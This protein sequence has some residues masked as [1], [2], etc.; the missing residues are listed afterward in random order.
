M[1]DAIQEAL[2][3]TIMR[4]QG[5]LSDVDIAK[6]HQAIAMKL[7]PDSKTVGFALAKF[8]DS[9]VGKV[10]IGY[11]AQAHYAETQEAARIGDADIAIGKGAHAIHHDHPKQSNK[12]KKP[13]RQP[14]E[15]FSDSS[16][17]GTDGPNRA[18]NTTPVAMA[19]Y[20]H[21]MAQDH[22][23]QHGITVDAAYSE[24]LKTDKAFGLVWR[25]SLTPCPV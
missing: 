11:A 6:Q 9:E 25:A 2:A 10:A 21:G 13:A 20:C 22:A 14:S 8:Y 1:N 23:A 12:K 17:D 24:L 4:K 16:G 7:Y 18:M 19:K 15:N 5:Q 3:T